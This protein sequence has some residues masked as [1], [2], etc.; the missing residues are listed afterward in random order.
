MEITNGELKVEAS[1]IFFL[2]GNRV[3]FPVYL[4]LEDYKN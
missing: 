3:A 4:M 1:N 2:I